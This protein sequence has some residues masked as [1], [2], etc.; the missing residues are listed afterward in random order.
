VFNWLRRHDADDSLVQSD[1]RALI[2][3]LGEDAYFEARIWAT[4][5]RCACDRWQPFADGEDVDAGARLLETEKIA[6]RRLVEFFAT[7]P[8]L[9]NGGERSGN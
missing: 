2:E 6:R 7:Q 9:T 1:A 3:R 4:R 8:A 5:R